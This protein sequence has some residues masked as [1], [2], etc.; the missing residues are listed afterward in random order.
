MKRLTGLAIAFSLAALVPAYAQERGREHGQ[1]QDRGGR[2]GGGYIPPHGP[3]AN[4]GNEQRGGG[5]AQRQ[6]PAPQER[7][8]EAQQSQE[9]G[10][11]AQQGQERGRE[12]Q[13]NQER[14]REAQQN[15][16]RG[17]EAQQNQERGREAEHGQ[18]RGREAQGHFRDMQ[19]HPDLPH[20]H[21]NG[22]WVGHEG[23]DDARFHL[24]H[25]YEHGRF[26]LGFGPGHVF[27]LQGGN[28]ER[29]WFN[30]A[31]FSVAPFDYPY[32]ADWYWNSDPIVIYDDPDHPGWYLAYNARTGT[33][34]HVQYLG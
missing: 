30:N 3:P 21:S 10:R 27:H 19:G 28:R 23:R 29:F 17:R 4:R 12:A 24:A 32:V 11:E 33:Y 16:E 5:Q 31:Y 9:R 34:V 25:P 8:R 6:A 13:Q 2:V 26:A 18:E 22:E 15:Q 1:E 14:G 20:V 7:G